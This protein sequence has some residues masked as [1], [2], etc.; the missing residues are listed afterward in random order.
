MTVA[1]GINGQVRRLLFYAC[2]THSHI[3][4]RFG[5]IGRLVFRVSIEKP[6]VR[7]VAINDPFINLE[8]MASKWRRRGDEKKSG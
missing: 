5:R 4:C 7:V 8:Y 6:E 1:V 3:A 2:Q